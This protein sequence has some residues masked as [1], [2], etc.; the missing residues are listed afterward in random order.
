MVKVAKLD[1]VNGAADLETFIFASCGVGGVVG[2]ITSMVLTN[3]LHPRVTF[4][5]YAISSFILLALAYMVKD[6]SVDEV[7]FRSNVTDCINHIR[8]PIVYKT[9]IYLLVA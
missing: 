8:E 5:G 9:V 1:P 2:S 6:T 7:S 4:L 3:F